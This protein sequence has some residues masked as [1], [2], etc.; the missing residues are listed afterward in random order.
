MNIDDCHAHKV[1]ITITELWDCWQWSSYLASKLWTL[2]NVPHLV[3]Q[4]LGILA[5]GGVIVQTLVH[6]PVPDMKNIIRELCRQIWWLNASF[7][8]LMSVYANQMNQLIVD[9]LIET[10]VG[11]VESNFLISTFL[12][13]WYPPKLFQ[14][15][16]TTPWILM[17]LQ[18]F[19][20][21]CRQKYILLKILK[22]RNLLT[23]FPSFHWNCFWR[24]LPEGCWVCYP[25]VE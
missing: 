4:S 11:F 24:M 12:M 1:L 9:I 17:Q 22:V 19:D 18:T 5:S 14:M 7:H 2:D 25:W 23:I 3:R 13:F 20:I 8:V 10:G 16:I 21:W 6:H 15:A